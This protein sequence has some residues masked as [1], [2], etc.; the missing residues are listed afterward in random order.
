MEL[1]LPALQSHFVWGLLLGLLITAFVWKSGFT[2]RRHLMKEVKR[3]EDDVRDLRAHLNTQL[4]ITASGNERLKAELDDFRAQN[5][6]LRINLSSLQHKPGRAERRQLQVQDSAIRILRE[7]MQGFAPI[8]EKAQ[9]QAEIEQEAAENGL[10]RIFR[11]VIPSVGDTAP[12]F[13]AQGDRES[14]GVRQFMD[15]S[16]LE[17]ITM[18]SQ[19]YED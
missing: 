11:R 1:L 4:S 8:W 13:A 7:H 14:E 18:C 19:H 17:D 6:I 10:K 12:S 9:R 2:A 5:E 3:L 16:S 15:R